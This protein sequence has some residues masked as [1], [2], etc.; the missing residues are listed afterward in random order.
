[1]AKNESRELHRGQVMKGLEH[2][3]KEL[4]FYILLIRQGDF[5]EK[6]DHSGFC[7]G[8]SKSG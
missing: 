7:V 3:S 6:I 5:K 4:K 2:H 8:L 1:M